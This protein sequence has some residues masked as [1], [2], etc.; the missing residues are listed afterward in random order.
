MSVFADG[1][2]GER[3]NNGEGSDCT[4]ENVKLLKK[5]EGKA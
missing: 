3:R 2:G 5:G 1:Q 4:V